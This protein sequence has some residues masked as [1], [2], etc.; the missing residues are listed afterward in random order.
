MPLSRPSASISCCLV[1]VCA[2]ACHSTVTAVGQTVPYPKTATGSVAGRVVLDGKPLAGIVVTASIRIGYGGS[3]TAARATTG[4]D[5]RYALVNLPPGEYFIRPQ[6]PTLV[7]TKPGFTQSRE[8]LGF[9][10]R[11]SAGE[12][13]RSVDFELQ[14]GGVVTGRVTDATGNPVSGR[15]VCLML[16]ESERPLPN[17]PPFEREPPSPPPNNGTPPLFP[18]GIPDR[19]PAGS[20]PT[21]IWSNKR[22]WRGRVYATTDDRGIYRAYGL[23]AG[24]YAVGLGHLLELALMPD[25]LYQRN[26]VSIAGLANAYTAY[27]PDVFY[28]AAT[29]YEDAG[30]VE[31]KPGVQISD[32]DLKLEKVEYP[33]LYTVRGRIAAA[34]GIDGIDGANVFVR[35]IEPGKIPDRF[36]GFTERDDHSDQR[37]N[38]TL[39]GLA[40]GRYRISARRSGGAN[41]VM[42]PT[43]IEISDHDVND[44]VLQAKVGL[45][46]SGKLVVD[47]PS[48]SEPAVPWSSYLL[49]V[50]S[51]PEDLTNPSWD[52][53]K[54]NAD[55]SFAA[56]GLTPGKLQ[57]KLFSDPTGPSLTSVV[58]DGV[59]LSDAIS[60][61]GEPRKSGFMLA[62]GQSVD[63]VFLHAALP[64]ASL[65]VAV[66]REGGEWPGGTFIDLDYQGIGGSVR[67]YGSRLDRNGNFT[68]KDLLPG[69]Y[70][71]AARAVIRAG[72]QA[73]IYRAKVTVRIANNRESEAVIY[74]NA[75]DQP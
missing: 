12:P 70:T 71:L 74:I 30:L 59:A 19:I 57:F 63:N 67:G 28:P 3:E 1:L 20:R 45:T 24:R 72:E 10:L 31:V 60:G 56:A 29:N 55:G 53:V 7:V 4:P 23:P 27:Y 26:Y 2:L 25:N 48:T 36:I 62:E 39:A 49:M 15:R 21:V 41:T 47:H 43:E 32:I 50:S 37:G 16:L 14:Q 5:G 13:Q 64:R 46:V 68:I 34:D 51:Y 66:R 35:R 8:E 11:L 18:S 52:Q 42:T 17:E 44:V 38:F 61:G 40:P 69:E 54:P 73:G 65:R 6:T 9:R 75:P 22:S 58:R 33:V